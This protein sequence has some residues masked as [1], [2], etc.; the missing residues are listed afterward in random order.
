MYTNLPIFFWSSLGGSPTPLP[1][2]PSAPLLLSLGC[3]SCCCRV[4]CQLCI[5]VVSR[6]RGWLALAALLASSGLG[7]CCCC[8]PPSTL[9]ASH[10]LV[11][12]CIQA[13]LDLCWLAAKVGI[14][15][16]VQGRGTQRAAAP[17]PVTPASP[18]TPSTPPTAATPTPPTPHYAHLAATGAEPPSILV[19]RAPAATPT[20]AT[21]TTTTQDNNP[22]RH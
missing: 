20:A 14:H 1:P 4:G 21:T 5:Q 19:H 16:L 2:L 10:V 18:P 11:Q 15:L 9:P 13:A 3:S 12:L 17:T 6:D 8:L 22:A 7:C